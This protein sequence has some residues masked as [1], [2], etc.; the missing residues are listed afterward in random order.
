MSARLVTI[1]GET[2]ITLR[3]AAEC[4]EVE[5]T[6]VREVYEVGLLGVGR[7]HD[8]DF[9]VAAHMLDRLAEVRRL[10]IHLGH[11]LAVVSAVLGR[12]RD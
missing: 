6:W 3:S 2:Y 10:C 4:Y 5:Y 9:L 11:D 1:S 7:A 12:P 8:D